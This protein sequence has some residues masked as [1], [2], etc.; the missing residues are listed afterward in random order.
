L[1]EA[2]LAIPERA[3]SA[4]NDRW[5]GLV[6]IPTATVLGHC[7]PALVPVVRLLNRGDLDRPRDPV[8]P[9]LPAALR[10][11]TAYSEPL[12]GPRGS[13]KAL[14]LWLTQPEHPLTA[15]VMVNRIWQWHFGAGLVATPNDFGKMGQPPSHPELLDWLAREFVRGGWSLK[16]IHRLIMLSCTYQMASTYQS[17]ANSA[18][19]PDNRYLWRM[20]RRRLEVEAYWDAF[21]TVAGTLNPKMGGRPI[22]PPLADDE[23]GPAQRSNWI[24]P[25]DPAEHTRRGMYI[26]VRRNFVF[27]MF[28]IFDSPVN[29]V[30]S[31]RREVTNVAPQA[32]WAL[33]NRRVL[34]QA[35]QFAARLVREAG[36]SSRAWVDRAW[37]VALSRPPTS[38]ERSDALRLLAA[39][40]AHTGRAA[41][42]QPPELAK[43]PPAR[44]A[45]LTKLCLALF[46]LN[47]FLYID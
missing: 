46:N 41:D 35:R 37:E 14:A 11:A 13:R 5:D 43:I 4:P 21:H 30:S 19:D 44:A 15:R 3:T 22:M 28:E 7:D 40:S 23:L 26:L 2:V 24:V 8:G 10:R 25:A 39:F 1:A 47:E 45:A 31:A 18:K 27:P 9:D 42:D 17:Q 20:N 6:E 16:R 33:N 29:S 38:A 34:G 32:L 36:D 12:P